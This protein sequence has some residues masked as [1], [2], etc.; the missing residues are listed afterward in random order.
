MTDPHLT[1]SPT[2]PEPPQ[3][4]AIPPI[5][6]LLQQM[7]SEFL[8]DNCTS[9][10]AAL[11]YA[12]VFSFPPLMALL[13]WI[14]GAVVSPEVITDSVELQLS[15]A[16]GEE[17][18]DG[19]KPFLENADTRAASLTGALI[20]IIGVLVGALGMFL[21]LHYSMNRV[22]GIQADPEANGFLLTLLQRLVAVV[23]VLAL[24]TTMLLAVFLET[25]TSETTRLLT[26]ILP[27]WLSQNAAYA[28]QN[29]VT[30]SL[31]ILI[32][33]ALFKFVPDARIHLKHAFYGA[34]FTAILFF[35]GKF[36]IALFVN[37]ERLTTSYGQ[38]G[39]LAMLMAWVYYSSMIILLGAE[40]V[41]AWSTLC[42]YPIIPER[43]AVRV[44]EVIIR[45]D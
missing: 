28:M 43:R 32:L 34:T 39:A 42:G 18:A 12:T 5:W 23:M 10:A 2:S 1:S 29:L 3:F 40:F 45:E 14:A 21:Q 27:E 11:S 30:M 36:G 4:R 24:I 44:R 26:F 25:L 17:V 8:A 37:E 6:K 33:T 38:A 13:I 41:Q 31:F 20:G 9:N 35:I 7:I 15:N 19:V 16:V 22:W